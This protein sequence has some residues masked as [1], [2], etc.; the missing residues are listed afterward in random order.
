MQKI[1]DG[2]LGVTDD[3]TDQI[4]VKMF[5]DLSC[6]VLWRT[7]ALSNESKFIKQ[8]GLCLGRFNYHPKLSVRIFK[9]KVI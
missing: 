6:L 8:H 9:A 7:T 4:K 3:V 5:D 2:D 1:N